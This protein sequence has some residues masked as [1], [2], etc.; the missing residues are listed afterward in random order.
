M[1]PLCTLLGFIS[2]NYYKGKELTSYMHRQIAGQAFK[3]AKPAD[4]A[5][6]L[7]VPCKTVKYTL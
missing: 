5:I 4:I 6:D 7:N 1:P 3:G 2:R